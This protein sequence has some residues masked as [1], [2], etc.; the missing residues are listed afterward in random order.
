MKT[1]TATEVARRFSSVLD[2]VERGEHI[3]IT[4]GG[5]SI[6]ELTPRPAA[7]GAAV[8][9]AL[10]RHEPDTDWADDID[11]IRSLLYIEDRG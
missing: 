2:S 8:R 7:N 11:A 9:E 4:R 5:R 3:V 6:A 1:L 10:S